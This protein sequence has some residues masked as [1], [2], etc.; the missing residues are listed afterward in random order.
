MKDQW[1][2]KEAKNR[3]NEMVQRALDHGPQIITRRG[4]QTAVIMSVED[5]QQIAKPKMNIVDIFHKSPLKGIEIDLT[6][7]KDSGREIDL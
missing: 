4:I 1:S 3:F 2:L 7:D 6:R 5:Y